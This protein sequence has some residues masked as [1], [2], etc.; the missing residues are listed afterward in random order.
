MRIVRGLAVAG[1]LVASMTGQAVAGSS[2]GLV[3]RAMGWAQGRASVSDSSISCQI[4]TVDTVIAD[5]FFTMGIWNT[6]GEQ[7]IQFPDRNSA[8]ANPCGGFLQLWNSMTKQGITLNRINLAYRIA[9]SR[10]FDAVV[11]QRKGWPTACNAFRRATVFAGVRLNPNDPLAPPTGSGLPNVA[12]IQVTPLVSPSVFACLREQYAVLP[13]DVYTDFPLVIKARAS[14][15]ADNGD[16]FVSNVLK[17][18]LNLRHTCGNGRLDDG[19]ACDLTAS[20]QACSGSAICV[21]NV[22]IGDPTRGCNT[23]ADCIGT[24]Q[25]QGTPEECTCTY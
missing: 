21:G 17:Y 7:T 13:A 4:P 8:F 15:I 19:E 22:C 25:A 2:K 10:R 12:F 24:C 11:S 9:G 20:G 5:G 23:D 6:F 3:L 18:T 14:G 1:L 16:R